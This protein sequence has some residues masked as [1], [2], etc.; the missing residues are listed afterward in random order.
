LSNVRKKGTGSRLVLLFDHRVVVGRE[1]V[2]IF[3]LVTQR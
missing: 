2:P 3:L 1:P